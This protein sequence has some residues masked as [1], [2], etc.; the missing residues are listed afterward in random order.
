MLI[1]DRIDARLDVI[2]RLPSRAR[3]R[4]RGLGDD[5]GRPVDAVIR[6]RLDRELDGDR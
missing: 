2:G 6:R 5:A 1:D 4:R 3:L